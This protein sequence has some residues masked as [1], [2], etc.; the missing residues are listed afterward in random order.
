[1][2]TLTYRP[3]RRLLEAKSDQNW[4]LVV[5]ILQFLLVCPSP[6][7]SSNKIENI[8]IELSPPSTTGDLAELPDQVGCEIFY[9]TCELM[10]MYI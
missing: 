8:I 7:P 10:C 4:P 5:E 1:M 9:Q 6:P 3:Y 2:Y